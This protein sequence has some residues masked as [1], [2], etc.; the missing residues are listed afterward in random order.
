[1]QCYTI[2]GSYIFVA[3]WRRNPQKAAKGAVL[4]IPRTTS[5]AN[6]A[7][8]AAGAAKRPLASLG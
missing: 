3:Q 6:D 7:D 1:M 8:G 2:Y 4:D 5:R